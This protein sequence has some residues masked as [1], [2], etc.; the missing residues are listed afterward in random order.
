MRPYYGLT[1]GIACGKSTAS[2]Y[3]RSL[4]AWVVDA[5]A[6]SHALTMPGG[7]AMPMIRATFGAQVITP[8]GALDRPVMRQRIFHDPNAKAQLEGIL[9]PLIRQQMLSQAARAGQAPYVLFDIPLLLEN[10][11]AYRPWLRRIAVVHC[12]VALQRQR[13]KMRNGWDDDFIDKVLQQQVSPEKRLQYADD[14]IW[15]QGDLATLHAQLSVLHQ[16]W[17]AEQEPA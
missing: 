2:A 15:N 16:R 7:Q 9:H 17:C 6:I 3:L 14:L 8:E 4:G 5:D 12:D 13:L 10:W 11:P 1:G